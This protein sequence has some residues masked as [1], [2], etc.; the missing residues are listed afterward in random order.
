[1]ALAHSKTYNFYNDSQAYQGSSYVTGTRFQLHHIKMSFLAAGWTIIGSYSGRNADTPSNDGTTT[2]LV[3]GT[4]VW[5]AIYNLYND[6]GKRYYIVFQCPPEMGKL[7]VCIAANYAGT[8]NQNYLNVYTS[9]SGSF[10]AGNGGVDGTNTA[11]PTA[12]DEYNHMTTRRLVSNDPDRQI[13]VHCAYSTD[14]TQFFLYTKEGPAVTC[15][16][17]ACVLDSAPAELDDGLVYFF[18]ASD[19][20]Q[21]TDPS[22]TVMDNADHYTSAQWIGSVSGVL[23]SMY[24]GGRGWNNV[25]IQSQIK[26]PND[27]KTVVGPCELY[28]ST[29]TLRGYYGTIPDMYWGPNGLFNQGFGD[30]VGG[31]INW[32]SGGSLI[33][34]WDFN[35]PLPRSD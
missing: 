20:I 15:F 23:R 33:V 27:R 22:Q 28:I 1:M 32:Y 13:S 31:P 17:S 6:S 30:A 8:S 16:W 34:P 35:E 29:T 2:P 7:H 10:C 19:A 18:E 21:T 26:V 3:A 14:G 5:G 24:L 9:K 25:G 12:P 11:R 4:D